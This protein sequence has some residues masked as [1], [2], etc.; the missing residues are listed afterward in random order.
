MPARVVEDTVTHVTDTIK[1]LKVMQPFGCYEKK[2]ALMSVAG[3]V[4]KICS[5]GTENF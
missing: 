5:C 2:Y 4:F 3:I 1:N